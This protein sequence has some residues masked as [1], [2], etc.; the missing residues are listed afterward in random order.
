[1]DRKEFISCEILRVEF[2]FLELRIKVNKIF[3]YI[4]VVEV[5]IDICLIVVVEIRIYLYCGSLV[6]F[7]ILKSVIDCI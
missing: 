2:F 5:R 1:M 7:V 3:C 4:I 6:I